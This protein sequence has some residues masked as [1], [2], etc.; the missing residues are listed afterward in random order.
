[1]LTYLSSP[2]L[3]GIISSPMLKVNKIL[4]L[5]AALF[6]SGCTLPFLPS[7]KV[8]LQVNSSPEASVYLNGNHVGK[9]PYYDEKLKLGEYTVR[10]LVENDPSKDWQ[11]KVNLA[12]KIVTVISKNFGPTDKESSNY[13]LQLEPLNDKN[14]MELAI[15]SI[16][17]NVIVKVDDQPQGFSPVSLKDIKEGEHSISLSAPGY[18]EITIPA[19]IKPGFKLLVSATL[20][21]STLSGEI[22]VATSSADLILSPVATQSVVPT[23]KS[24]TPTPTTKKV[25]P[26][27]TTSAELQKPYVTIKETGTGW[28]R[29][30]SEPNANAD[31]EVA[32]VDTGESFPF[33]EANDSGWY[34]IEYET[35]SDGWI[36]ARYANLVQ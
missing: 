2:F 17:D 7:Q 20:G 15:I 26:T 34:K 5:V 13:L 10:L 19:Q 33:I 21:Q 29:V 18:Q 30:R 11:T 24:L 3:S 8:A 22:P 14:A 6:L 16:P 36:S 1:M 4:P 9:T 35:G 12:P 32:K 23:G 28:L 27:A 31:N 25:T